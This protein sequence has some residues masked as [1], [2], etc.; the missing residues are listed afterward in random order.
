ML[1]KCG[2]EQNMLHVEIVLPDVK[3][4]LK[5]TLKFKTVCGNKNKRVEKGWFCI[6]HVQLHLEIKTS[7]LKHKDTDDN[8]APVSEKAGVGLHQVVDLELLYMIN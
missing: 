2:Q 5:Y 8:A 3:T 1:K 7:M 4:I 6:Q